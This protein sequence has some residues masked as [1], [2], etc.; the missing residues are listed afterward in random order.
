MA[1]EEAK[2]CV[3]DIIKFTNENN[4]KI[5]IERR[6]IEFIEEVPIKWEVENSK[7][8]ILNEPT[9]VSYADKEKIVGDSGK[10]KG[11]EDALTNEFEI[12][13][14][15]SKKI[16]Q[17]FSDINRNC[18]FVYQIVLPVDCYFCHDDENGRKK[19][20]IRS[21]GG[22]AGGEFRSSIMVRNSIRKQSITWVIPIVA[23]NNYI[24]Y[25]SGPDK[26]IFD[27]LLNDK[28]SEEYK[29]ETHTLKENFN[30]F[31]EI[32]YFKENYSF[33]L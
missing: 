19:W 16:F 13:G 10:G 20:A 18:V 1:P 5:R 3:I 31:K 6:D 25:F 29:I 4:N 11:I 14:K 30:K 27:N 9:L 8:N 28:N 21:S 17:Y 12:N 33:Y 22:N 7:E 26:N 23:D 2:K 24:V 15:D 32:D